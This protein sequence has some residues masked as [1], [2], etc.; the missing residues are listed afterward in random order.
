MNH[1]AHGDTES[2]SQAHP[3]TSTQLNE[4]AEVVIGAAIEV[5]R[6]LGAGFEE[7]TYHR[8]MQVE[9]KARGIPYRC[10]AP[11]ELHC[12]G[13]TIGQ[14]RIDLLVEEALVVELKSAEANPAKY[15][16]QV[17]AYLKAT[18]LSLGLVINFNVE[19]LKDGVT[20]VVY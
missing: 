10:E 18:G 6:A 2:P 3:A 1:R 14:G 7:A 9:L 4:L 13:V 19:L 11:V 15:R 20:R 5:H 17:L 12:R 16:R 8:A